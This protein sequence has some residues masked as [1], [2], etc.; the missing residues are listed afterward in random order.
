MLRFLSSS[1]IWPD[2]LADVGLQVA[3]LATSHQLAV[4]R[5]P[6]P[7]RRGSA[8]LDDLDDCALDGLTLSAL[9]PQA[10]LVLSKC[11]LRG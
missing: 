5:K 2:L 8:T 4:G 6:Q 3:H 11:F 10:R 1:M 9:M 7:G